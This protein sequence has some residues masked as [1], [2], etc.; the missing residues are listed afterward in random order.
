MISKKVF[1]IMLLLIQQ[2]YTLSIKVSE[3]YFDWNYEYLWIYNETKKNFS[4]EIIISWAKKNNTKLNIKINIPA[5]TEIIIWDKNIEKY[6]SWYKPYKTWLSL[7]FTDSSKI[8]IEIFDN[9]WNLL[10]NLFIPENIVEKY[11]NKNTAFEK[12]LYKTWEIIQAIKTWINN[13]TWYLV[14]PW[15]VQDYKTDKNNNQSTWKNINYKT[16]LCKVWYILSWDIYNFYFTGNFSPKKISWYI[17]NKFVDNLDILSTWINQNSEINAIGYGSWFIC[18]W[19]LLINLKKVEK[20]YT[21][22]FFTWTLK[23]TEIHPKEDTFPEYIELRAIWN[24]SWNVIFSWLGRGNTNWQTH[25][26]LYSWNYLII[27]KNLSWF[28]NTNILEYKWISLMDKWE[29]IK[30][31][32][33]SW[34]TLNKVNYPEINKNQSYYPEKNKESIPTP[35]FWLDFL[36]Y[37]QIKNTKENKPSCKIVLQSYSISNNK[38][39]INFSSK[40]SDKN[41]CTSKYKQIW[42]YS[43]QVISTWTCN[44][45]YFYFSVWSWEINFQIQDS[46]WNTI[47]SSTY[48]FIY[49]QNTITENTINTKY[50]DPTPYNCKNLNSNELKLLTT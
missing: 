45:T 4:D 30:I 25:I 42:T 21:Q 33:Q 31:I 10:D 43:W 19:T 11:N 1:F 17:N 46:S 36:K 38:L 22:K 24:F 39:K 14:N 15:F 23:I 27:A 7:S 47:C 13:A 5:K 34:T 26:L 18:T 32:S 3:V 40:I 28:K 6:F 2:T 48:N 29:T 8:N 16:I 20:D 9:N 50:L 41:L 37:Y 49:M 35:G 12:I 44:P